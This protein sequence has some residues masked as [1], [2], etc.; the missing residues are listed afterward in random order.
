CPLAPGAD[1]LDEAVHERLPWHAVELSGKI[2]LVTG[3]GRR[4]GR[5]IVEELARAGA[6]GGAHV[7]ASRAPGLPSVG[8]ARADLAPADGCAAL[9]AAVRE[10]HGRIDLLVNSAAGYERGAFADQDDALWTDLLALNLLAPAR[11]IR[12]ALPLGVS[13]VVNI[14]DVAA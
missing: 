12:A 2:A 10:R 14:V 3:G 8:E 7:H 9:I 11:L 5:A 13:A 6:L 4:V 1:G